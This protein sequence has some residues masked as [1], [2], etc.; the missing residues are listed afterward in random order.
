MIEILICDNNQIQA[1]YLRRIVPELM[2]EPCR[3]TACR[4]ADELR[5][6]CAKASPQIVLMD[7]LLEQ[8]NGIALAKELFP[9][10]S[11]TAVIF[12]SGYRE[13]Y[14]DVY[15]AEHVYFLP[16]PIERAQLRRALDKALISIQTEQPAFSVYVNRSLQKIL[17]RDVVC[18]ESFYGRLR[19]HLWRETI[20][21]RSAIPALPEAVRSHMIHCHKS[22]LANPNYIRTLDGKSFL[23]ANGRVVPISRNRYQ[24][25]RRAFLAY[26]GQKLEEDEA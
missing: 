16:K 23:M 7:I 11:G 9:R 14:V 6:Q 12:I 22:F 3:V 5:A 26:C 8:E 13:Y 2:T 20:E 1:D 19:I 24:E 10:R 15:E 21:S 4:S 17:L 18:I 25:S